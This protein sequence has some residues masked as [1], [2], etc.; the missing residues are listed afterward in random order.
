MTLVLRVML[1]MLPLASDGSWIL[2]E[3]PVTGVYCNG[4]D[5]GAA[6]EFNCTESGYG[7]ITCPGAGLCGP[8][9]PDGIC[10]AAECCTVPATCGTPSAFDCT[11]AWWELAE[12]P[13]RVTCGPA[14]SCTSARCCTGSV[15]FENPL[16][17]AL[18]FTMLVLCCVCLTLRPNSE[19][20]TRERE[21]PPVTMG[22]RGHH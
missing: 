15:N 21:L 4:D 17:M 12:E 14:G 9:G 11:Q 22:S 7:L 13:E 19:A 3:A 18:A 20:A 10:T 2:E 16:V 1:N 8:C 5:L 6:D